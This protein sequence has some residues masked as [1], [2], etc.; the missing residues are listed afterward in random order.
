VVQQVTAAIAARRRRPRESRLVPRGMVA[1]LRP[2]GHVGPAVAGPRARE[3]PAD[4][5]SAW[6]SKVVLPR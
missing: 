4:R 2:P 6:K 3:T 1:I 5:L